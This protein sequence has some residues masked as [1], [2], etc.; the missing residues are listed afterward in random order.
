MLGRGHAARYARRVKPCPFCGEQ[1]QEVAVKCR[2]CGEWLD[3]SKR[4]EALT[5][6]A[7]EAAPAPAPES[8]PPRPVEAPRMVGAR[9]ELWVPPG[10]TDLSLRAPTSEGPRPGPP[11]AW[12]PPADGIPADTIRG[13]PA[14]TLEPLPSPN[15]IP[16]LLPEIERQAPGERSDIGAVQVVGRAPPPP[17]VDLDFDILPATPPPAP[18]VE[19]VPAPAPALAP[20]PA[21]PPADPSA[22]FQARSAD[23]FMQAFLGPA[24]PEIEGGDE[25][26][27]GASAAAPAPPPPWPWIGAVAAVVLVVGLYM[28]RGSLFGP[29]APGPETPP[30][31]AAKAEP[32]PEQKAP[33]VKPEPPPETKLAEAKAEPRPAPP[34]PPS[35]PAFAEQLARAKAAYSDG[36]LKA[37]AAALADLSKQAPEHPEV[38]LLTAQVQLEQG[39]MTES[40]ATADRCV[41]VAPDLADCWLTLGVLRQSGKDDAGAVEAYE[42][43]LKLA[44]SGRY[45]RDATSQLT[46]LRKAG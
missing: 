45:A 44:P 20:P 29:D 9:T 30:V 10:R 6:A 12:N 18:A 35:D 23:A 14:I 32:Q 1:I 31:E 22:P 46:R 4:P 17:T 16:T 15:H 42:T 7:P 28:F 19:L 40:R 39:K 26:P 43:Y 24:E 36:K 37:T 38:L 13:V 3:P 34:P 21:P 11:P 33:E 2:Y 41:A 5:K 8:V 27:F 25:D